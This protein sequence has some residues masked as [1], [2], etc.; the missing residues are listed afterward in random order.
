MVYRALEQT[1]NS[2]HVALKIVDLTNAGNEL[3]KIFK[4]EIQF[5]EKLQG[6]NYVIKMFDQ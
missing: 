4:N 3:T 2:E 1:P 5:L 6:S